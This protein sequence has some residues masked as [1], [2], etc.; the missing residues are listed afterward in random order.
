MIREHI[1]MLGELNI[2]LTNEFGLVK[3]DKTYPNLV[4]FSGKKYIANRMTS[5]NSPIMSHMAI[6]GNSIEASNTDITLNFEITRIPLSSTTLSSN[7]ITY[8][9]SFGPYLGTGTINEAG[10]FNSNLAN[11]G[12][13]LCRTTFPD[14]NKEINDTLT[15]TWNVVAS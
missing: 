9:A 1:T 13:M 4:V 11:S 5:N 6:G 3:L 12:T 15:I 2:N 7:T 10:I 8:V 14:I